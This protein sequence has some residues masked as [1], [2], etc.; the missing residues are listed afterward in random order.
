MHAQ[1]IDKYWWTLFS[2]QVICFLQHRLNSIRN[3]LPQILAHNVSFNL[4]F[5]P[6]FISLF[7][8]LQHLLI[9]LFGDI[10]KNACF[11]FFP[12]TKCVTQQTMLAFGFH[13]LGFMSFVVLAHY[14]FTLSYFI[15]AT[16]SNE[17]KLM[18][19]SHGWI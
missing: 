19:L 7:T 2:I 1:L 10:L 9:N 4:S 17:N 14:V 13:L 8:F 3:M 15:D 6:R 11:Y 5:L 12:D 16:G 18:V